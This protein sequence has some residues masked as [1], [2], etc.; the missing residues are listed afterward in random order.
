M[1]HGSCRLTTSEIDGPT[2]DFP[3]AVAGGIGSAAT[4]DFLRQITGRLGPAPFLG[5]GESPPGG[6]GKRWPGWNGFSDGRWNCQSFAFRDII[7]GHDRF[8]FAEY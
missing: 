4:A 2:L 5:L 1:D 6:C 3:V 7:V 8:R